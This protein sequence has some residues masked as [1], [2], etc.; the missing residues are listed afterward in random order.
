MF[1]NFVSNFKNKIN[2]I[3]GKASATLH[4]TNINEVNPNANG[5]TPNPKRALFNSLRMHRIFNSKYL[6]VRL[7]SN[8]D[9][10]SEDED[11]DDYV[12]KR[13]I[14]MFPRV[15]SQQPPDGEVWSP[16]ALNATQRLPGNLDSVVDKF[17]R[18]INFEEKSDYRTPHS[19][20]N[21]EKFHEHKVLCF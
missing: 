1:E 19:R 12:N 10:L 6:P 20:F 21:I 3:N 4:A 2:P 15:R 18:V 9:D 16:I 17:I 7:G 5:H 13:R 11:D 14:K 8:A